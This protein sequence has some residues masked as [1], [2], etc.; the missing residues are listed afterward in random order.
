MEKP[1]ELVQLEDGLALIKSGQSI[2]SFQ[3]NDDQLVEVQVG[4]AAAIFDGL[5]AL[6]AGIGNGLLI[7]RTVEGI[8]LNPDIRGEIQTTMFIGIGILEALPIIP[9]I[10]AVKNQNQ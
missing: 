6:G 5:A 9:V 3:L 4:L 8:A 2:E 10:F 1:F 7:S